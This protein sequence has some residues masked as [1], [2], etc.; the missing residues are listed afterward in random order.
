[1]G[2]DEPHAIVGSKSG[3]A[4]ESQSIQVLH[5]KRGTNLARRHCI[6]PG[7]GVTLPNR[8]W[9]GLCSD[10]YPLWVTESARVRMARMRLHRKGSQFP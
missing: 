8:Y 10:H 7:C 4:G 5:R 6:Y 2:E 3:M 1:M 9:S